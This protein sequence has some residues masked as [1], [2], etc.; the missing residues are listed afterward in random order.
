MMRKNRNQSRMRS[1]NANQ[2]H[3]I[4]KLQSKI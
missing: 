3:K 2:E 1:Q 4:D